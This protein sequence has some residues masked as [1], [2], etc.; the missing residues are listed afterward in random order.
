LCPSHI[1][2]SFFACKHHVSA[3]R[4]YKKKSVYLNVLHAWNKK[5]E[6]LQKSKHELLSQKY[7]EHADS[8]RPVTDNRRFTVTPVFMNFHFYSIN[9]SRADIRVKMWKFSDVSVTI[10]V[11]IFRVCWWFGSTKT[12]QF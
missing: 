8:W 11:P 2:I 1:S 10:S 5:Q 6:T 3:W 9:L 12:G 7:M 4:N